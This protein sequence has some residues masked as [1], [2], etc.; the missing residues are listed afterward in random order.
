MRKDISKIPGFPIADARTEQPTMVTLLKPSSNFFWR[1]IRRTLAMSIVF[2]ALTSRAQFGDGGV[3]VPQTNVIEDMTII[4][5]SYELEVQNESDLANIIRANGKGAQLYKHKK[6]KEAIPYLLVGAKMGFKMS[7]ARLGDIYLNGRGEVPVDTMKGIGWH[8]VAAS[9]FSMP[10]IRNR[11]KAIYGSVKNEQRG[12]VDQVASEYIDKYGSMATGTK[13]DSIRQAGSHLAQM[14]CEIEDQ[15]RF[16]SAL[17]TQ[18]IMCLSAFGTTVEGS[19]M[20]AS[21]ASSCSYIGP[22]TEEISGGGPGF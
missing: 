18:D 9:P 16:R 19:N 20:V 21:N 10:N 22:Q 12:L 4:G 5:E 17:V 7:Q 11:W 1:T 8:A 3:V 15:Y 14:Y 13:C 6:Y 2:I